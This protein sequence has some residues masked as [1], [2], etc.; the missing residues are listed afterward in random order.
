M[1]WSSGDRVEAMED[2]MEMLQ[3]DKFTHSQSEMNWS[4]IFLKS[5]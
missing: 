2:V 1:V 3:K 4:T 5:Q